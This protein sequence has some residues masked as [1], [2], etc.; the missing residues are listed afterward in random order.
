MGFKNINQ[1]NQSDLHILETDI[2]SFKS[3]F[4]N[5]VGSEI[6]DLEIAGREFRLLKEADLVDLYQRVES[7]IE[8]IQD[9]IWELKSRNGPIMDASEALQITSTISTLEG[10]LNALW[11]LL[12]KLNVA[13]A[14]MNDTDEESFIGKSKIRLQR[15]LRSIQNVLKPLLRKLS[16]R[17]W[18]LISGLL[19]PKEWSVSG[20]LGNT[21]LGLGSVKIEVKFGA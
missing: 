10:E 14:K 7:L 12:E 2:Q 13:F 1:F 17:L 3:E 20:E 21:V 9:M 6:N 18:K 19:T 5:R 8:Q 4:K 16:Q 11:S 15:T